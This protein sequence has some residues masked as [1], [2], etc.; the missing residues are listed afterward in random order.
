MGLNRG[1]LL[2]LSI[3]YAVAV[4]TTFFVEALLHL[5]VEAGQADSPQLTEVRDKLAE[6]RGKTCRLAERFGLTGDPHDLRPIIIDQ[7]YQMRD[8]LNSRIVD[9]LKNFGALEPSDERTLRR[10]LADLS[11][12]TKDIARCV[13]RLPSRIS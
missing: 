8:A 10:D 7:V 11:L 1:Q 4:R 3:A 12:L 13:Q 6:Y 5:F 2:Q 9:E